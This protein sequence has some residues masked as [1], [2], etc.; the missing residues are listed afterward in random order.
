MT[1]MV[2]KSPNSFTLV[3]INCST[4]LNLLTSAIATQDFRPMPW[5]SFDTSSQ[6]GLFAATVVDTDVVAVLGE[7]EGDGAADSSA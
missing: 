4:S 1:Y 6:P 7:A 2:F 3:C 5:I